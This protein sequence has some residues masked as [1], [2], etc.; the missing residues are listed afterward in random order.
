MGWY[1]IS[2]E[3]KRQIGEIAQLFMIKMIEPKYKMA[4]DTIF[5]EGH[6]D[7]VPTGI[8]LRKKG[9]TN[10]ELS[11]FRAIST[12]TTMLEATN[13][14]IESLRNKNDKHLLSYSGYADTRP[15]PICKNIN[16]ENNSTLIEINKCRNKNR[17]IEFYFTVNTPDTKKMKE[18]LSD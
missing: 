4:I 16:F 10:K 17:R 15:L 11:T 9:I 18:H 1:I 12:Y 14:G 2:V 6:T 3:G 13:N 8:S 5:I 7:D